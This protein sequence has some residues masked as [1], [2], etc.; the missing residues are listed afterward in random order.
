MFDEQV[1]EKRFCH[2]IGGHIGGR[3]PSGRKRAVGD[4]IANKM[5][6]DINVF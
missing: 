5:I 1:R 3:Y 4:V 6:A 2:Y